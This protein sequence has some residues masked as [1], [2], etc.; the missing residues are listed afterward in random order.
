MDYKGFTDDGQ[1]YKGNLHCHTTNSDGRMTPEEAAAFYKEN[2]YDFLAI[3]DHDLYSDYREELNSEDFIILPAV[4]AE[5]VLYKEK[6]RPGRKCLHHIHGILGTKEMQEHAPKGT[7]KHLE[8]YPSRRFYE[9]WDGLKAGQE[10]QKDLED[11]G[12]ITIYN[13]PVW[14]RVREQEFIDIQGLTAVEIYNYGTVNE[15]ATGYDTIHWD[16]MLQNG[17]KIFATA[18]DDN[19][20]D[21]TV[22]DSFGGYIVVK[23]PKLE[24]EKI[25]QAIIDGNYYSSSGPEIYDWG[26]RDDVAYVEY[27][28]VSR[29]NFIA[30][31]DVNAGRTVMFDSEQPV[32]KAQFRLNGTETYIRVECIDRYGKTAW[33]NPI[34]L[35]EV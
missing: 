31:N 19:H 17:K 32:M 26:I 15:S 9:S 7:F 12:C 33:T 20:N 25:V 8:A 27:S 5:A 22:E 30:G 21:G 28:R 13:H 2:G 1:W 10:L 14:S 4:E 11:H 34:F 29:V 23:A 3:S 16:V 35:E 6:G 18:A 24:H